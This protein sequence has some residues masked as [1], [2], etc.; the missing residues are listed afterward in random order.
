MEVN[1]SKILSKPSDF[2]ICKTCGKINWYENDRCIN[3]KGKEFNDNKNIVIKYVE[4]DIEFYEEEG[5][6]EDEILDNIYCEV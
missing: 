1:Y 5:Y 3:C 2:K 6:T 4:S